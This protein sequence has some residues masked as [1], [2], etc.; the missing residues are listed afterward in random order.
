MLCSARCTFAFQRVGGQ[1]PETNMRPQGPRLRSHRGNLIP[2]SRPV[3]HTHRRKLHTSAPSHLA[4]SLAYLR[5]HKH[6]ALIEGGGTTVGRHTRTRI[7]SSTAEGLDYLDNSSRSLRLIAKK[8]RK[9][10]AMSST[11]ATSHHLLRGDGKRRA[12]RASSPVSVHGPSQPPG[13][14]SHGQPQPSVPRNSLCMRP[15]MENV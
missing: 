1:T 11:M 13:C 2:P 8:A 15:C 6:R 14:I 3:H 7:H 5:S 4:S 12:S 10:M 9:T